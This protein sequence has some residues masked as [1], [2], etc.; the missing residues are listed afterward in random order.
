MVVE[1][2][3]EVWVLDNDKVLSF[4]HKHATNNSAI[5]TTLRTGNIIPVQPFITE[6]PDIKPR[7]LFVYLFM[8]GVGYCP[9]NSPTR[10]PAVILVEHVLSLL[11]RL[12]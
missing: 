5:A 12:L 2:D 1:F 8:T 11:S 10:L 4:S 6:P 9:N 3:G 7:A